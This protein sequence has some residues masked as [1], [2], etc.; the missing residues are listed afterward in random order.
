LG[1]RA[2]IP[3][4]LWP[5]YLPALRNEYRT[6]YRVQMHTVTR[7]QYLQPAEDGNDR[8]PA[9]KALLREDVWKVSGLLA[10]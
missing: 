1:G 3:E 2:Q 5:E 8:L 10:A 6:L 4:N 9:M 7:D